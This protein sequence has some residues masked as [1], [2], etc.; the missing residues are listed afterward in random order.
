MNWYLQL[1]YVANSV[2][3][4]INSASKVDKKIVIVWG[5]AKHYRKR[6]KVGGT[7]VWQISKAIILAE[8]SLVNFIHDYE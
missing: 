4:G 3:I 7:K 2:L 1:S 8:E 5:A 6:Q